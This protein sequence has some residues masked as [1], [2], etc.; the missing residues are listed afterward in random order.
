[1]KKATVKVL[2]VTGPKSRISFAMRLSATKKTFTMNK[3]RYL[4]ILT[5]AK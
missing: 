3:R 1:M 5:V 4:N 2:S